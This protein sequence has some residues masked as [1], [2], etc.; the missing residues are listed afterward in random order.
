M[1]QILENRPQT[2]KILE[3]NAEEKLL[4]IGLIVSFW[5]LTL[6][7]KT[8]KAK[9]NNWNYIKQKSFCTAKETIHEMKRQPTEQEKIFAYH[10]FDKG[11]ISRK[12]IQLM[13]Q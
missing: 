3:E 8:T 9:I 1:N 12:H 2:I 10:I 13:T 7:A 11:L 5:D 6:K 4:N